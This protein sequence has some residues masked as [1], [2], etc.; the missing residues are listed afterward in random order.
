MAEMGSLFGTELPLPHQDQVRGR[1][2][3]T[4]KP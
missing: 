2:D 1:N 4:E 3:E